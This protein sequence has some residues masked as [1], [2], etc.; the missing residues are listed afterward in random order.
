MLA[1]R[2]VSAEEAIEALLAEPW[3][4]ELTSCP[5]GHRAAPAA[6]RAVA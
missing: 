1:N 2:P 3:L 5:S 6:L 4:E